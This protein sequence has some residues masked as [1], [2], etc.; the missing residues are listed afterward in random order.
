MKTVLLIVMLSF[1]VSQDVTKTDIKSAEKIIG[2]NFNEAERDS[3]SGYVMNLHK[4]YNE[5]RKMKMPNHIPL[6]LGFNPILPGMTIDVA[7]KKNVWTPKKTNMPERK[8]D[9]AFYSIRELAYLIK[10]KKISS[11]ELTQFFIS[12]M[13]KYDAKLHAVITITEERAMKAAAK[14]DKEIKNGTYRGLLH[15]IPFGVKDLLSVDGY[16]TTWGA[17]P[18]KDQMIAETATV[19]N[20]LEAAGGIL[21]AK[22]T[23]GALAWGDVW[24]GEKTRNPWNLEQG[25]SGSSAGSASATSAG[26]VPYAIG[27]ET[28]GSIVS[29][30]LRCGL[31]GLRPTFGRVSKHG[32]M[33]LS[34]S[35]DKLGPLTRSVEDAAI[36]FDVIHGQ[37]GKDLTV[38]DYPYHFDANM[39]ISSLKIG[40]YKSA[41]DQESPNQKLMQDVLNTLKNMN[42]SLIDKAPPEMNPNHIS[43]ILSSEAAAAFDDLTL[44]NM[45][46]QLVRQIK[47]SWPNSFRSARFI[48]AVEYIQANR[49]RYILSQQMNDVMKDIDLLIVPV[50]AS[51]ISL[52]TNLTGHPSLFIPVGFNERKQITG[53]VVIGKL[54]DEGR[55]LSFG[56]QY[57]MKTD[58]HK[59]HP[60]EFR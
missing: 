22:L 39:D 55:I 52:T 27:S 23:L 21:V 4:S 25:S 60:P 1:G 14:A 48:T 8:D 45:D 53:F 18:F 7:S 38:H 42:V 13:K 56:H 26:L 20:K 46:D 37:D 30:S 11:V 34:W 6:M 36:V 51:N 32:A 59:Q 17:T 10:T 49:A 58:F 41:F 3:L 31:T 2:L 33:A 50:F 19:V 54:F 9:L 5:V 29:P 15:G 40:Y 47:N 16:K 43:V 35:M 44:T 57:Q 12:R 24:F 28:W